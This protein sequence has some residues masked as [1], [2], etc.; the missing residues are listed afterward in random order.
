MLVNII[1]LQNSK[2]NNNVIDTRPTILLEHKD[3][4]PEVESYDYEKYEMVKPKS[5]DDLVL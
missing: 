4:L 5:K 1:E 3:T 2:L